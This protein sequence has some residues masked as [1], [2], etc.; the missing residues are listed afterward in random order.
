MKF[1]PSLMRHLGRRGQSIWSGNPPGIA[2]LYQMKRAF[3]GDLSTEMGAH[4]YVKDDRN[5][6]IKF[7]VNG[8]IVPKEQAT[9]NVLDSGFMMGDGVWEGVRLYEGKFAHIDEH[10]NRLYEGAK[11]L[12]I[13][14]P[15]SPLELKEE[16]YRLVR[17]NKMDTASGVHARL[18]V[19]RGLKSTPYQKP[20]S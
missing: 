4:T 6:D 13:D 12:D 3:S 14:I 9:V 1:L 2:R 5:Q 11:H 19:T 15:F 10:M 20:E 7:Y 18:M 16:L 8:N 17:A